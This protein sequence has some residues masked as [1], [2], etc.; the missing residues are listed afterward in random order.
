MALL[1]GIG[2][3]WGWVAFG[4][5]L[6]AAV[7]VALLARRDPLS[8]AAI[9]AVA[10]FVIVVGY[11]AAFYAVSGPEDRASDPDCDGF[12]FTRTEGWIFLLA[13]A[14]FVGFCVAVASGLL[15]A[16]LAFGMNRRA[17]AS[18]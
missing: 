7:G 4:V 1:A 11:A 14:S 13:V 15:A 6:L 9:A 10:G 17:V 12:C 5:P 3:G 18:R 16:V 8:S 2:L